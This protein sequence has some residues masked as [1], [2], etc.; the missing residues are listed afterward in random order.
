MPIEEDARLEMVCMQEL[1][2]IKMVDGGD[3]FVVVIVVVV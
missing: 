2:M 1:I 3:D